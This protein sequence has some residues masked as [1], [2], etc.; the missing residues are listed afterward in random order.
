MNF[1]LFFLLQSILMPPRIVLENPAAVSEIPKN[2]K[3]DYD[4]AWTR[5]VTA[6]TAKED[7]KVVQDLEKLLKKKRDF[8]AALTIQAYLD[9][10]QARPFEA[11]R[12]LDLVLSRQPAN[13]LAL[14]YL[15]ELAYARGEYARAHGLYGRLIQ[16]DRA[17][18]ET[19]AK[20]QKA[21]LLATE[22]LLQTAAAAEQEGRFAVAEN[23][24]RQALAIAPGEPTLHGQ[25]ALLFAKQ[26]KW[27]EALVHLK[28]QL[29]FGGPDDQVHRRMAE[30]LMNL[31]R[32]EEARDVL[33]RLR[34][35]GRSD[36]ELDGKVS[37]LE[38]LGRWGNEIGYF[39]Q[40]QTA[41]EITRE[42]LSAMIVRYF[43]QVVEFRQT[44]QIVTDTQNSWASSE[45]QAVVGVGLIA[46]LP[47]HTFRPSDS[48]TRTELATSLARLTRLLSV[49][50]SNVPPIP[51]SD[52]AQ[53]NPVYL[54]VQLVLGYGLMG[55]DDA[56][57][58]NVNARVNGADTVRAIEKL[59]GLVRG[60]VA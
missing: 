58:F 43:P 32:T 39:R 52:L 19:E 3:K 15:A 7:I 55:L 42:Q 22:N 51:V 38:D 12:R 11:E 56:G 31:G 41:T 24:Y 40:I 53:S 60:K 1:I 54:D 17:R 10:Y 5:F 46:P 59:L 25:I 20:R 27:E 2:L 48:I 23:F 37:E 35:S 28:S 36:E 29:E 57:R 26:A 44:P 50:A 47:N 33:G 34:E 13:R 18:P 8:D 9:L 4:K 30:A 16:V 6:A 49:P 14:Y 21:F 45:I